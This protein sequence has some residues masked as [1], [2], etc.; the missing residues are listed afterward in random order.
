VLNTQQ[1]SSQVI[2]TIIKKIP[3]KDFS[4][5]PW[6]KDQDTEAQCS[7]LTSRP[8]MDGAGIP[9]AAHLDSVLELWVSLPLELPLPSQ[10]IFPQ[11]LSS[12]YSM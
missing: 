5:D 7:L 2:T 8:E 1:A 6:Y 9:S 11:H 3:Q 4:Y 10:F 12:Q